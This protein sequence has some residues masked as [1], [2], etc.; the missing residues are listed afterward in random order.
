ML[1]QRANWGPLR[2]SAIFAV[3]SEKIRD[4]RRRRGRRCVPGSDRTSRHAE[5]RVAAVDISDSAL[6]K[7]RDG[8]DREN[9]ANVEAILGVVDDPHLA[10]GR[11][12]AALI[13]NAYHEMSEHEAMLAHIR[14]ALKRTPCRRRADSRLQP[15]ITTREAGG[16]A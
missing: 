3:I 13:H 9:I 10:V 5:C 6:K 7:L 4:R 8:T 1:R 11:F 15:R 14:A 2:R 16:A 12:D